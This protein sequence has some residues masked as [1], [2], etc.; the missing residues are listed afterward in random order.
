MRATRKITSLFLVLCM[1]LS[2]FA[3]GIVPAAADTTYETY[4]Q[5]AVQ[6]SNILHCFDWS[7]NN[8]KAA[9][10]DIA[11]AGY[12]A[13]QTSPV[14]APKDYSSSWTDA[15][16]QWWKL[17][18]PLGF[19][20]SNNTWLGTKAQL[21]SLCTEAEKYDIK[22]IVDVVANHVANNG[23]DGGTYSYTNS[24]VESQLNNASFYHTNN[25]RTNDDSRYNITQY[26]LGMPDLNTANSTVQGRVIS[27]LEE[28]IDCGVDGF[29]FDAAKHIELPTDP[30]NCKSNFWP[31]VLNAATAYAEDK[32]V[33]APFYY[34]EILGSAGPNCDISNYTTYMAVTDNYTGDRALDK[35]YWTAASELADGTYYKGASAD[36]SVLWVESHDTY[37]GNSGSAWVSNTKDVTSDVL[38][39]AWAIVGARADSTAL[40]FARPN[41]TMGAA[42]SD[43]NWKSTAV[44]EVNKFKNHFVGT[45]EYLSSSGNSAYIER[46][47]KG[48]VIS[49]LD[50]GG[51]VSLTAHQMANG[52]YTDQITGNTFTV[53]N[54]TISGTVGSTGVAVVY[55]AAD[56]VISYITEPTLY[57]KPN[58]NWT[59]DSARFAMY[60]YNS[61]TNANAWVSMT[62]D[63]N[64][65]YAAA[66]P[67]GN[68]TN[69]IF[70]R[71]NPS[72]NENRWDAYDGEGHVWNQ[73]ND[74][75]PDTGTNCYTIDSGAWSNGDGAWSRYGSASPTTTPTSAPATAAPTTPPSDTNTIYA[76][77]NAGWSKVWVHYWG[78]GETSWPGTAMTS[79]AGTKV[80]TFD[81]PKNVS[82]IVFTDGASSST[83]QTGDITTGITDGAIW[84]I[85][86]ANSNNYPVSAAPDYYLVGTMNSWSNN[87]DYKMSLHANADGKLEYVL[88][89]VQ[90][91]ANAEFKVHSSS[92]SWYPSGSNHTVST[93]GTY[94]VYFRPNGDG[95]SSW[96]ADSNNSNKKYLC[97][98]NV[99]PYTVTWKDGDNNVLKTET[100]THGTT[101][102]YS[103]D[104]P[105]KTATAQTAYTF[106]NTW[107]PA[108]TAATAD[109]V[110]TAQFDESVRT[111][112]V[113][114]KNYDGTVLETDTVPYGSAPSYDGET[115]ERPAEGSTTYAFSGWSPQIT[116]QT[117][118]TGDT[119]YTARFSTNTQTY[120]IRWFDGDGNLLKTES[121][122]EGVTPQYTGATPTKT[123]TAQYTY[124]FNNTWDPVLV[125]ADR[126]TDYT[127]QFDATVNQYTITFK[128][129]DGT[130]LQTSQVAY[131]TVPTYTGATPTKASTLTKSYTFSGWD[132]TPVA[133]TGNK[134]YTATF[135][136]S[137]V[138]AY[139]IT[140]TN[141]IG[142][143]DVY[144]YYWI[145]SGGEG[146]DNTWPG[147]KMTADADNFIWT[148]SIPASVDGVIFSN[149]KSGDEL[150]QTAN[151]T[152]GIADDA[153]WAIY[154]TTSDNDVHVHAVPTY[155][156]VG[157][158]NNWTGT[159]A[160]VFQPVKN[161]DGLEEYK[162]NAT[163]SATDTF[164]AYGSDDRWFPSGEGNNYTLTADGSYDIYFRPNGDGTNDWHQGVL[165]AANV[166]PYTVTW[167]NGDTTIKTDTVTYGESPAYTSATPT[168]D[169]TAQYT[170][171]FSGWKK[172]GDNTV[173]T[174]TF[175]AVSADVTYTA[176]F[177]ETVNQYTVIWKNG[178]T[179]LETDENVPYGT[180]PSYD[181]ATPTKAAT[182][183]YSY[184]FSGWD[185]VVSAVTD[186][187]IYTAQFTSDTNS[188]TVTWL[189]DDDSE[190]EKD[191]NVPYGS[192]PSY[193]GATP[194]KAATAQYTYT[195]AGWIPVVSSVTGDVTYKATYTSTVNEYTVTWKDG[196]GETLKTEQVA[197]GATPAYTG[198]TP[199]KTATAQYTYTFNNTWSPA[200]VPVTQA[201]TYTAQ[202][203][204]AVNAYTVTW[205]NDDDSELEKDENVPYGSEP[206]YD[207]AT[208]T[209]A[210]T[211]QYTY[212]FAGWIPVVSS[213]TGDVTYK[214]TYTST[215]NEY[216]VTWKDGNGE[217]LKTEQVAYGA[218][219]AYTGETPTKTA[220]DQYTY[221]FNNTWTPQIVPVTQAATYTAQ[222]DATVNKYEITWK[223]GNGTTLKTEE[224]AYGETPAY[225]G[226]TPTKTATDQYTYTFNNTWTPQ[227]VPVTQAA[228]YTAQFDSTVRKYTITWKDEDNE[229]LRTDT[230]DYGELPVYN[231]DTPTKDADADYI[232]TF[233]GWDPLVSA[234]NGDRTYTAQ[235]T[236][237]P[238]LAGNSISLNG[239]IDVNFY[240]NFTDQEISDGVTVYFSWTVNGNE[241][242]HSVT[243]TAGDKTTNGYMVSCPVAVAE[244]T[245]TVTATAVVGDVTITDRY[246]AATYAN[247]I[248]SVEYKED[249]LEEHSAADYNKLEKLVKTMLDYG[250]KAQLRFNRKTDDL[251]NGGTDYYSGAV[252]I[253]GSANNM[254]DTSLSECGLTY[255]GTSVVYLSETTLRHYYKIVEPGLFTETIANA[256]TF[257][258]KAVE[259]GTKDG[260]IYFDLP[261]ITA[262]Q[263]DTEYV[264]RIN[265]HDYQ[266]SV[267]DYSA[268]SY[269]SDGKEYEN[270]IAKQ[271]AAAVYRY[272]AAANDYFND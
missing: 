123:A 12:T 13:V 246:S 25:T 30:S 257:D 156:L 271:L 10:P 42:S 163:L 78:N 61:R 122:I 119:T 165:Y 39:K 59:S 21:T 249:Y 251:A 272:N 227:I 27:L 70:V 168:R 252:E 115:P 85:G 233:S 43:N 209:K 162:V 245:Y 191:E 138:A 136:E 264:L 44:A 236:E 172:A 99:T 151:I 51:S 63:S 197:Y 242:T 114:W 155:Y 128:N 55:N 161:G 84:T 34:G 52:T 169:A 222:F 263:L 241:K 159:G 73:T 26:H 145:G 31:N 120:T 113:T 49:K 146:N 3:V 79:I 6:G 1:V 127:A 179:V 132:T 133:V 4:A 19:S 261:N 28:C 188:Y 253:P 5:D 22:V 96:L 237:T 173:Y 250:S 65:Y 37:M 171:T 170:Y 116:S 89:G 192:E 217:T 7:Y 29:R 56:D 67:S 194:T 167:K 80:Y 175:P 230:F 212:T 94:D 262:S 268:L 228:T 142:W 54:G 104:T 247:K 64:G 164:K 259:Y 143:D 117:T 121:C 40:F 265:G 87:S 180:M 16:N 108:I 216:T 46:G 158:M 248:L 243:L 57:L 75:F 148:G 140:V 182:A 130:V 157:T 11:R 139:D 126:D 131:G 124:T 224:V 147:T 187:V 77:N 235:Y 270:S 2:V 193:D 33:D 177:T 255:V 134:T 107:S 226:E 118:I 48:V 76:I 208:P 185:P 234:V 125:A 23:T 141:A 93:A 200:I 103:G 160:P 92:D 210:A 225:T 213:V 82:G 9:L 205:L 199:T 195:F 109:T 68:W 86:S 35:A 98:D 91:S 50:G 154:N 20:I 190:L 181:G 153:H 174:T 135:T 239:S 218:T 166:T 254:N 71:M 206:S 215:V 204:S 266:Y 72:G 267:L 229:T 256:I 203:D 214:A 36:K 221:T 14:Q 47:T 110:Y 269:S 220:T 105:T 201:A 184:L 137:A 90:L 223:D 258:G 231:G 58:S 83:K 196:N 66:V 219:P 240:M 186:D 244:M 198:E 111:Y 24:G 149:G 176:Y 18:Q 232:Y 62:A 183:Q 106:N 112:T 81:L 8:I 189:N 211:A 74:L 178:D 102:V 60:V 69:V 41:S 238:R 144:V 95:G 150:K 88:S 129:A 152:T 207:G 100:V 45:S 53:S 202:F 97:L 32:G 260:M 38:N 17:Y 15:V 101:P